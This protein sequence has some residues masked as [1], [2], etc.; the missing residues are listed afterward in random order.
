MIRKSS[1]ECYELEVRKGLQELFNKC[2]I[3]MKHPGDLLLCQ[4]NGFI[5]FNGRACVGPG[6]EGL[7][8][9]QQIN[10]ISYNGIGDVTND[11]DYYQKEGNKFFHGNSEF[12]IDI[13]R[14]HITYMNIWENSF[15]LR[16]FT[17]VVNVLNSSY[18]D[19][20]LTFKG[21]SVGEKSKR[22]REKII[23]PLNIAPTFQQIL[24]EAYIGQ[25]RNA[26]AHAQY[27]CIQGG[28]LY[29]NY[30]SDKYSTLQGLTFEMWEKKYIYS[31]FIFIGIFQALRQFTTEFYL[32]CSKFTLSKGIPILIPL[33]NKKGYEETYLYPNQ[34]GDVWRFVKTI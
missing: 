25:I 17:Q 32:T 18:Y 5:D 31:Y 21:L 33:S 4:Q 34:K 3:N 29:D 20:N 11:N 27:H 8:C 19:W 15:F 13:M 30:L 23:R 1:I 14:Q 10:S 2:R 28:I 9:M 24:K 22:I 16:V 26:T 7:D 6:E 12:E